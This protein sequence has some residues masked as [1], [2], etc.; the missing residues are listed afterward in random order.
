MCCVV[1]Y[2]TYSINECHVFFDSATGKVTTNT[3]EKS[4]ALPHIRPRRKAER[5]RA[6]VRFSWSHLFTRNNVAMLRYVSAN[7]AALDSRL[8][9]AWLMIGL[10]RT[11]CKYPTSIKHLNSQQVTCSRE[12]VMLLW[13]TSI[14]SVLLALGLSLQSDLDPLVFSR[15]C[16]EPLSSLLVFPCCDE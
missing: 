9:E 6:A 2:C 16:S 4:I 11:V 8:T 13:L 12:L 14:W 15:S 10:P 1:T 3:T 5:P 7:T